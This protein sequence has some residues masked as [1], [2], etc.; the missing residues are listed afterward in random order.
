MKQ[1]FDFFKTEMPDSRKADFYLGCLDGSVFIDFNQS[2]DNQI[3]LRRISFDGFGC[4]D[5][6][7]KTNF[8]D[9]ELSKKFIEEIA[10][11]E[12]DQEK[13]ATLVKEIIKINQEFIW[14][15]ALEEYNL[16]DK[17]K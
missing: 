13:L 14:T 7:D 9:F 4:C 17:R 15:D 3:S 8:L 1:D 11:E 10:K 5:L 2:N 16:I 12:L 6:T